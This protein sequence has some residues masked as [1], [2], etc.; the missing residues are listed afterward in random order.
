M[1]VT[2]EV[3]EGSVAEVTGPAKI[4]VTVDKPDQVTI[5]GEPVGPTPPP[6]PP[7]EEPATLSSLSPNTAVAGDPTDI[8]MVVN[9]TGFSESSV[10]VFNGHDEPTTLISDTKVSTGVKPSLFVVPAE[11][12]VA[13]RN[14]GGMSNELTFSFTEAARSS[15]SR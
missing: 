8:T 1:A 6:D 13:V 11:C 3:K 5:D 14:A 15:R 4:V 9:G 10:I 2:I 12:P 7:P